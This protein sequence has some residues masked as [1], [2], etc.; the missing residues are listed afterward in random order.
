MKS[1]WNAA[2]CLCLMFTVVAVVPAQQRKE[3]KDTEKVRR[4]DI[5][6]EP[7][8]TM[9]PKFYPGSSFGVSACRR[10]RSGM[11]R[12]MA[13]TSFTRRWATGRRTSS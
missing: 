6:P 11:C 13:E 4:L 3:L 8:P 1:L 10:R 5:V 2:I 7:A 12:R 9:H